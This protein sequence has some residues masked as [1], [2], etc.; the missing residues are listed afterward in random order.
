M[1][2]EL[3]DGDSRVLV[4][5]R[6]ALRLGSEFALAFVL[7]WI[8]R[9]TVSSVPGAFKPDPS[10][11]KGRH[12]GS[13]QELEIC[14]KGVCTAIRPKVEEL[15]ALDKEASSFFVAFVS[16]GMDDGLAGVVEDNG[17]AWSHSQGVLA[18]TN[19]LDPASHPDHEHLRLP[20]YYAYFH[21]HL[22]N[23]VGTVSVRGMLGRAF[24]HLLIS[25]QKQSCIGIL[26]QLLGLSK[27][28]S[29]PGGH[30]ESI[31]VDKIVI[32]A[33]DEL[34]GCMSAQDAIFAL[35]RISYHPGV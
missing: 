29:T 5:R 8:G 1:G 35:S 32:R 9:L 30:F 3:H 4:G 31:V 12:P 26:L 10:K 14:C 20:D 16:D 28:L 27:L 21:N 13:L 11:K 17:W 7:H 33:F 34:L 18:I 2:V 15:L 6:A 25:Y 23:A 24:R 19:K 22:P